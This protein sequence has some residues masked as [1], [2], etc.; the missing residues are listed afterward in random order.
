M[1]KDKYA[2]ESERTAWNA[3]IE[4]AALVARDGAQ[5]CLDVAMKQY[6]EGIVF[7]EHNDWAAKKLNESAEDILSLRR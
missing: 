4:A 7:N 5:Y 1:D 6:R 2:T 3:A